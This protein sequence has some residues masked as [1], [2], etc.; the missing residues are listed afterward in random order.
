MRGTCKGRT[1][2]IS[3]LQS[4]ISRV[5]MNPIRSG[6]ITR[7]NPSFWTYLGLQSGSEKFSYFVVPFFEEYFW[8]K[9]ET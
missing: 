4:L 9:K 6:D 5:C 2:R 1:V 3:E 8:N 7:T